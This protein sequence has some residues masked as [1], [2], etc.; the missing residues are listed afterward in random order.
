MLTPAESRLGVVLRLTALGLFVAAVV[1][2]LGPFVGPAQGFFNELPFVANSVV[3]VT[4]LGLVS[5]YA[6]GNVRERYGLVV[7]LIVA[8]LVSVAAMGSVLLWAETGKEVDLGLATPDVG[9][10]LLYAIG[11][12]GV[13]TLGV[14]AF[15]LAAW[16]STRGIVRVAPGAGSSAS[17]AE[18]MLRWVLIAFAVLFALGGVAYELAPFLGTSKEFAHELPFVTNSVVRM[19]TLAMLCA[20]AAANLK[21][22]VALVG[23]VVFAQ[24]LGVTV[25][26]AYLID[27]YA[28][29]SEATVPLLGGEP[30]LTTVMWWAVGHEAVSGL[31]IL[32]AYVFALR[33]RYKLGFLWP[34]SYRG[35]AAGAEVLL[36]GGTAS[37]PAAD[38]AASVEAFL[39]RFRARRR[40]L[41]K[42]AL[43]TL[44]FAPLL[45]L[46]PLP[47]VN[48]PLSE[49]DSASRRRF[50]EQHFQRLPRQ[51]PIRFLK[52][53][54]QIVIRICLQLTYAGY[55]GDERSFESIGYQPFTKR[56][57]YRDLQIDEPGEHPLEVERPEEIGAKTIEAEVCI[58]G[59]GAGGAILA[60]QLAKEGRDVLIL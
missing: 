25:G 47:R 19:A 49:L 29:A 24:L 54:K 31:I 22:N 11:L 2:A 37:I 7:I 10:V 20:Y 30:L 50:L 8:H 60:H 27:Q 46:R 18:S 32:A 41:Y 17:G 4:I 16:R 58:V 6:A 12:D 44:Q 5:L 21:R 13:I 59:S 35:L 23:P 43:A 57:R 15:F 36:A 14:A 33:R 52:N 34:S 42:V 40:W 1:Y 56:D 55:Y 26:G 53:L 48:P 45:E 3:K 28:T 9:T 51:S 38:V 39:Q